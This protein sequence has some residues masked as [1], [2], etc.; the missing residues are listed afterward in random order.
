[1]RILSEGCINMEF[2]RSGKGK[3]EFCI[4]ALT[5]ITYI[6]AGSILALFAYSGFFCNFMY[7][8]FGLLV[9]SAICVFLIFLASFLNFMVARNKRVVVCVGV[10]LC[11]VAYMINL[12]IILFGLRF[13]YMGIPDISLANYISSHVQLNLFATIKKGLLEK[14]F[15]LLAGNLLLLF[16]FGFLVT[17]LIRKPRHTLFFLVLLLLF[18]IAIEF[19]QLITMLGSF[20]VDDIL[21][22]YIGGVGGCLVQ[23]YA[24]L[25]KYLDI[26]S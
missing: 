15:H 7:S 26:I 1:M 19:L 2:L 4:R 25:Y 22:N 14:T 11:L 9:V 17:T 23:R 8:G 10:S 16:P 12:A 6:V 20:D 13:S 18:C 3:R 21:L 24:K 5:L